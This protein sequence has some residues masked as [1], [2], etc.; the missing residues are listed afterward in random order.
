MAGDTHILQGCGRRGLL[1]S[2][3]PRKCMSEE[4]LDE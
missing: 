4:V 1:G 3:M 2:N